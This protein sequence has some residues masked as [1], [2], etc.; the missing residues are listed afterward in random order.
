MTEQ[1]NQIYLS[2]RLIKRMD[3]CFTG[4]ITVVRAPEGF[5]KSVCTD[6]Y[7]RRCV[8][9]VSKVYWLTCDG[10]TPSELSEKFCAYVKEIDE[11]AARGL[12]AMLLQ[13]LNSRLREAES[14]DSKPEYGS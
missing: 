10:L 4:G 2:E 13:R 3:E 5:G 7:F 11:T 12:E 14:R 8:S 1:K 9:A 6:E